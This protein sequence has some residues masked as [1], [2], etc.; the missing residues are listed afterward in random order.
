MR[1]IGG[2]CLAHQSRGG[3]TP[4]AA[5]RSNSHLLNTH[6]YQV[7]TAGYSGTRHFS[8]DAG[9]SEYECPGSMYLRQREALT[10]MNQKS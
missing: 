1:S 10:G 4:P 9:G 8:A 5:A 3:T 7:T 2:I 6:G